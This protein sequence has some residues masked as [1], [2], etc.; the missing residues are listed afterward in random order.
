MLRIRIHITKH[1]CFSVRYHY[2]CM[3]KEHAENPKHVLYVWNQ[4][5]CFQLLAA[6]R[7]IFVLSTIYS[8][9]RQHTL[10]LMFSIL[11]LYNVCFTPYWTFK[12]VLL[13]AL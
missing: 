6:G 4:N 11:N 10:I 8:F 3:Y 12:K 1:Y 5:L 2:A 13:A 7:R 9:N